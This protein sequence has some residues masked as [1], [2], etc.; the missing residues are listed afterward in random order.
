MT[1]KGPKKRP[2]GAG[3]AA[4]KLRLADESLKQSRFTIELGAPGAV[5]VKGSGRS[6]KY[7]CAACG[8]TLLENVTPDDMAKFTSPLLVKCSCGA[9]NDTVPMQF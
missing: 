8:A 3:G 4:R 7:V 6:N 1:N 9:Y 2:G 5:A